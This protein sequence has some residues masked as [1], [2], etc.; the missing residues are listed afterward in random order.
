MFYRAAK[1]RGE[2]FSL[3]TD[4]EGNNCFS[5][6]QNMEMKQELNFYVALKLRELL[7]NETNERVASRL[8]APRWIVQDEPASDEPVRARVECC[9]PRWQILI[10]HIH[11]SL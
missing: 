4:T 2:Y 11:M 8:S 3:D 1:R 5:I 9:S 7:K 10:V 6:C